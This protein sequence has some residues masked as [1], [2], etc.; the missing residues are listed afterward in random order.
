MKLKIDENSSSQ[1]IELDISEKNGDI[2]IKNDI[3]ETAIEPNVDVEM[4]DT[5]ENPKSDEKNSYLL[6]GV[7][8]HI[9]HMSSL[10]KLKV[11]SKRCF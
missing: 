6:R 4:K 11:I 5:S 1:S 2:P 8:F 7:R 10:L 3:I 9:V